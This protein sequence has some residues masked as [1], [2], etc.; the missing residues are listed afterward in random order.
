M[1]KEI[2]LEELEA[3]R[4]EGSEGE[5]RKHYTRFRR[6]IIATTEEGEDPYPL[7]ECHH[8]NREYYATMGEC[9]SE[10]ASAAVNALQPLIDRVRKAE[11]TIEYIRGL[12]ENDPST[13]R[14]C[15]YIADALEEDTQDE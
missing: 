12:L 2:D 8:N 5:W 3:L 9:D 4:E 13:V 1:S 11:G 14:I 6:W 15:E 7:I 10:L